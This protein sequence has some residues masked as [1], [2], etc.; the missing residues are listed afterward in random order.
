MSNKITRSDLQA[1]FAAGSI[2]TFEDFADIFASSL[3]QLDDEI[4]KEA[5][6]G[7][8][9]K[10]PVESSPGAPREVLLLY[11][12]FAAE[13]L[14]K[15][16]VRGGALEIG[17]GN[18]PVGDIAIDS[19]GRVGIG[20]PTPKAPLEVAISNGGS[21][22]LGRENFAMIGG[23]VS[24]NLHIESGQ[25][26]EDGT[27]ATGSIYLNQYS[28]GKTII[29]RYG[30]N[31]GIGEVNPSE[32]LEV[33]GKVKATEFQG[34]FFNGS[35]DELTIA[36]PALWT[37]NAG[38]IS[39]INGRVGIGIADPFEKLE[40]N[41]KV[42]ATEFHGRFFQENGEEVTRGEASPWA[43]NGDKLYV[44]REQVGIG[45]ADP[46]DLLHMRI[47]NQD[48][49]L[50][51]ESGD[52]SNYYA[53]IKLYE[54][55]HDYGWA[56]RMNAGNDWLY[57]DQGGGEALDTKWVITNQG[58]VGIGV[59]VPSEKLE[60]D[61][62][63]KATEFQGKFVGDGSGLTNL[64]QEVVT[65]LDTDVVGTDQIQD[66][67]VTIDKIADN[68]IED[69][70]ANM[71]SQIPN[72]LIAMW[73]GA[74]S[75]IPSGWA[76]CDGRSGTPDL[77]GRFIVGYAT[78]ESDYATIGNTGGANRVSLRIGEM[79]RHSHSV[80]VTIEEG[81]RHN[82]EIRQN[83]SNFTDERG[84]TLKRSTQDLSESHFLTFE[85]GEHS[86]TVTVTEE[87][88]GESRAHENRPP[89]YVLAFIIKTS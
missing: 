1:K 64:P 7:L 21:I 8:K 53:G 35:G 86:H 33:N 15:V 9:L 54:A 81:G 20:I 42:K 29:N 30:G 50:R 74:V 18:L 26:L 52:T 37:E 25:K 68:A 2:P 73:S 56:I 34:R 63:I 79:P 84:N 10:I 55:T 58:D 41:G 14:W 80:G 87:T 3:N 46:V 6:Q 5:D 66:G 31:V 51:I 12:D 75:N 89:Y 27:W 11:E 13:S 60:V 76:L 65:T 32:K 43:E 45:L 88:Q 28:E 44:S 85:D 77:R 82:H 83:D 57:F 39:R 59:P 49:Y 47:F 72:G 38:D 69:L 24:N 67:A 23:N 17:R 40:V 19:S 48:N 36:P 71:P 78:N 61:G 16:Q 62:K 4:R 70:I 22:Q